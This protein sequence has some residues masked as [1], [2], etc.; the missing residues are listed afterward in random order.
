MKKIGVI[1][2]LISEVIAKM[3]HYDMLMIGDAGLPI[4]PGVRRIDL[5]L[6]QGVPNFIQTLRVVLS[7]LK[8]QSVV[9]ASE[10]QEVSPELYKKNLN[11]LDGVEV[12]LVS[13]EELKAMSQKAV[14]VIRTGEFTPYANII[15]KSGV[16]F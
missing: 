3:G 11:E 9:V 13:H 8:L 12:E 10:M 14:A 7:E 16:V 15:L 4:P 5:A 1:N 2:G 6:C